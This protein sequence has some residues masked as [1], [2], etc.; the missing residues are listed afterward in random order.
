MLE[1]KLLL[2]IGIANGAPIV[3]RKLLGK[4]FSLPLDG[5]LRFIDGRPLLGSSK[6]VLGLLSALLVTPVVATVIGIGF[7]AG[8]GIA[9][10]S[11]VGDLLSSFIKRRARMP[12]HARA[13]GLDQIPESLLPA[14]F[15]K[16]QYGLPSSAVILVV[17]AF[18]VIEILLSR[19]LYVLRI[20]GRPY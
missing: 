12:V 16:L 6:T 9:A 7:V 1:L 15:Y 11:M 10:W 17:I 3:A 19:W 14:L 20:R 5:D 13:T 8:I 18:V 4:R 2:L